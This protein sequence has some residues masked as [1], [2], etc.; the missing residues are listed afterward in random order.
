MTSKLQRFDQAMRREVTHLGRRHKLSDSRAF[1][2]WFGTIGLR[3]DEEEAVEVVS[4]DGGNDR[5]IDLFYV[6]DEQ[7]RIVIGQGKYFQR[8]NRSPK[9]AD[10]TLL[11]NAPSELSDP[12]ELL[13]AGRNDLA[14]AARELIDARKRGFGIHLLMVYPGPVND[15][16]KRMVRGHNR[17]NLREGVSASLVCLPDL[18]L[19]YEDHMGSS[20]RVASGVMALE[21]GTYFEQEDVFGKS[22]VAT[23]SGHELKALYAK[24][25]DRLFD[26][27]VRLFL[28]TRKGSVNAEIRDTL[29]DTQE[30]MYFWAYNNGITV[31]TQSFVIQG[32]SVEMTGFSIVNGCQ[33]TVSIAEASDAAAERVSVLVR[34]VAA[35]PALVDNIIRYTNSQNPISAWDI[36]AR[37]RIQR[38]LKQELESLPQPWFYALRRGELDTINKSAFGPPGARRT[39][40]F[41]LS[42]QYLAALKGMPVEAYKDKARLFTT[43]RDAVFPPDSSAGDVL[44]AWHVGQAVEAAIAKYRREF[45]EDEVALGILRRGARFFATAVAGHL[46]RLRNG[47]DVFGK[48]SGERLGQKNMIER[49]DKYAIAAV[50][51]YVSMVR[52]VIES[53]T[54]F[55]TFLRAS[56]TNGLLARRVKEGHMLDKLAPKA[57][58]EGLPRLPGV[59]R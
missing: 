57:L 6:D 39:L 50:I 11:F 15:E 37:D 25:G 16:L 2:A 21:R 54:E 38:R 48:V 46:L 12:Q 7:E 51:Q 34:I 47:D 42:A 43:H 24:H 53:G 20:G 27:N 10:L 28:G 3:L 56:E 17:R 1:L 35:K 49:L 23:I 8:A 22:L 44:W 30:R 13:D 36:S 5:G 29:Q 45:A 59:A 55:G 4:Y 19:A 52:P 41:P 40:P 9:P 32:N 18:V 33:T 58:E 31:V 26:Q 14:D